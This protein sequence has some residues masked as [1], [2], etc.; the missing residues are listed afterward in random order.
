MWSD[1]IN[2]NDD[3]AF[4]SSPESCS[5]NSFC[6]DIMDV[7]SDEDFITQLSSELDIPLLL[8]QGEDEMAVLN[9]FF[10][11]SSD[12][13]LSDIK[14]PA[15]DECISDDS[16]DIKCLDFLNWGLDPPSTIDPPD[17]SE[18]H[19]DESS[20]SSNSLEP[21]TPPA[22]T[23]NKKINPMIFFNN[24]IVPKKEVTTVQHSTTV[25]VVPQSNNG[26]VPIKRVP[27][28]PKA[29]Y[30]VPGKNSNNI[31]VIKKEYPNVL[32]NGNSVITTNNLAS[33][34]V[35]LDGIPTLPVNS[36]KGVT[37]C[38]T[39]SLTPIKQSVTVPPIIVNSGCNVDPKLLKRQQRKIKNRESACLSRK[40]KKDYL[41]SLED[42]VKDLC[43]ENKRLMEE[44]IYL[45]ERLAFYEKDNMSMY[46]NISSKGAKPAIVLC[47]FLLVLGLNF[48]MQSPFLTRNKQDSTN[49]DY[50]KLPPHH[51]RSLLWSDDDIQNK[52]VKN[53]TYFS[54]L[55]MCPASVNQTESARLLSELEKWIGKPEPVV[56]APVPVKR[57]T[58]KP[59]LRR[60]K[61]RI[62]SS[63]VDIRNRGRY[64]PENELRN[65][66][67]VF[68]PKPEH[69]YSEFF[70]AI[71]RRGDTFYVVS[72]NE[73]HM[74]LPAL[75]HNKTAR[76]KMS[77]LMPSMLPNETTSQTYVN[78]MQIDCEVLDTKLVNIKY[79]AIPRQYRHYGNVTK[80]NDTRKPSRSDNTTSSD[81]K[82]PYKP[83][84][85]SKKSMKVQ[86]FN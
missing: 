5:D 23:A 57:P 21:S 69:L 78:L 35:V 44:N 18:E 61:I 47:V 25:Q 75:H 37:P 45:K 62:D 42:K 40:K 43:S 46:S 72:F 34:V 9:S 58:Q 67:Q 12:E 85:L 70:E 24:N 7:T 4:K 17:K 16:I 19:S 68:D 83:Y 63:L 71:N 29:P 15:H 64:G 79:G 80:T 20:S 26:K 11:K 38:I 41:N 54:P 36:F 86:E 33:K 31:V 49:N 14:S 6:T 1:N 50:L 74:L 22:F 77:L 8:S 32:T 53:N 66:I 3:Y 55:T 82:K 27:I 13:I 73:Q 59:K 52:N 10:D 51:G 65:E 60:K 30:N 76:P 48:N 81:N 84:F 56:K 39:S 2:F 28:K